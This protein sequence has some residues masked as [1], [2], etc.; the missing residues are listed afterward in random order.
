VEADPTVRFVV[1]RWKSPA[2]ALL[3]ETSILTNQSS[4]GRNFNASIW[5][6]EGSPFGL[7]LDVSLSR[8][9]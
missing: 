8:L 1:S 7:E 5:H 3:F 9:W 4:H 2:I 6:G